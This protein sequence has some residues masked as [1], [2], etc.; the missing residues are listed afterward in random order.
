MPPILS[1]IVTNY[2]YT[3]CLPNLF[4]SLLKQTFKDFEVIFVDDCSNESPLGLIQEYQNSGLNIKYIEHDERKYF[5]N[6]LL[7]GIKASNGEIISFIDGDDFIL[8]NYH[9][10]IHT[11]LMLETDADIVHFSAKVIDETGEEI[12]GVWQNQCLSE[13]LYGPDIFDK[14]TETDAGKLLCMGMWDKFYRKSLFERC[15]ESLEN[16]RIKLGSMD[17][18]FNLYLIPLANKYVGTNI[19]VYGYVREKRGAKKIRASIFTLYSIYTETIPFLVAQNC[20]KYILSKIRRLV[21]EKIVN[22]FEQLWLYLTDG[23]HNVL[24]EHALDELRQ[25]HDLRDYMKIML[26][27]SRIVSEKSAQIKDKINFSQWSDTL[28]SQDHSANIGHKEKYG[29]LAYR[30]GQVYLEYYSSS[31][32]YGKIMGYLVSE[33]E[34]YKAGLRK[35]ETPILWEGTDGHDYKNLYQTN[36][37]SIGKI[38][39]KYLFLPDSQAQAKKEIDKLLKANASR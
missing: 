1:V 38:I 8:N 20:D 31:E 28:L 35:N 9:F 23:N 5:K 24:N 10:D 7:D 29:P 17:T 6:S 21:S 34:K 26:M 33:Y 18:F 32:A 11:A 4:N 30:L 2:N 15:M 3:H 25:F 22:D 12:P 36:A 14:L 16:S 39:L 13:T 37:Y 19:P 27:T